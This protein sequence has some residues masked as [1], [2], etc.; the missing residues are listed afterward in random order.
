[1]GLGPAAEPSSEERQNST[2]PL[3][4]HGEP[5]LTQA[6][7]TQTAHFQ[8]TIRELVQMDRTGEKDGL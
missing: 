4:S 8:T 5:E 7:N 2:A 1:M 6:V 3:V